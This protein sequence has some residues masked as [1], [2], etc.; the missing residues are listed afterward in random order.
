[1]TEAI[2]EMQFEWQSVVEIVVPWVM[3]ERMR[4]D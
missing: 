3:L 1:M 2:R 4:Y